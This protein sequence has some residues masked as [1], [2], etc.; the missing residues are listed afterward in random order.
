MNLFQ[1]KSAPIFVQNIF[2]QKRID[3]PQKGVEFHQKQL[4][5]IKNARKYFSKTPNRFLSGTPSE[6]D[7]IGFH[8]KRNN[9]HQN[10]SIFLWINH[11]KRF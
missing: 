3:F 1:S 2:S 9:F 8:Q 10:I 5:L 4:I 6:I 11:L 7:A